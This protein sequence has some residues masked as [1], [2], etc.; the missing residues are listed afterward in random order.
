MLIRRVRDPFSGWS[1]LCTFRLGTVAAAIATPATAATPKSII[2]LFL[3]GPGP[4]GFNDPSAPDTLAACEEVLVPSLAFE[5]EEDDEEVFSPLLLLPFDEDEVFSP[6]LLLPFDEDE[7]LSPLL[8]FDDD[9]VFSPSLAFDEEVALS[10][11]L[12]LDALLLPFDDESDPDDAVD[13]V[14]AGFFGGG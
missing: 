10:P 8:A 9:E 4:T 12:P 7:P 2:V 3:A 11:V 1:A 14:V 13:V 5:L 6:L